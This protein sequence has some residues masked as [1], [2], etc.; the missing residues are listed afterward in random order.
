MVE[1]VMMKAGAAVWERLMMYKVV[2][3][4]VLMYGIEI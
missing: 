4:T 1:T 3:K 2:V